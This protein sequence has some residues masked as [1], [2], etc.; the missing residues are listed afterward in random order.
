MILFLLA[1]GNAPKDAAASAAD[2]D[3]YSDVKPIIDA[4]C[5]GCHVTGGIAPFPLTTYAEAQPMAPAMAGAVSARI[6]PPWPADSTCTDYNAS[7]A[8]TDDQI[9]L[10]VGWAD[11]GAAEGDAAKEGL[12]LDRPGG[13]SRVDL[14]LPM[15]N[16]YTPVVS[17]DEYRCFVIDWPEKT[18]TYVTG[19]RAKPGN[20]AIVHHVIA[21]HIPAD[22]ADDFSALDSGA[23]YE[24]L[25][26][27]GGPPGTQAQWIGAWA[28]GDLGNDFP[29][30]T[31]MAIEAGSLVVLQIHYNTST[32]EA[33]P[34]VTAVEVKTDSSVTKQA[35]IVKW[36]DPLWVNAGTMDIPAGDVTTHT[37]VGTVP[38]KQDVTV[39]SSGL[40]MHTLGQEGTL[41]L[42][43]DGK[44]ECLLEIP[45]WDFHWQGTY[46]F[47]E[48]KVAHGG[49]EVT[50]SCTFNN[51]TDTDIAWGEGTEDEMCLGLMYVTL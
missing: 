36:F 51:T 37:W 42:N 10:I 29:D 26:G 27:P 2:I 15:P 30:G 5:T 7:R 19:F 14:D 9:A 41:S 43:T 48:P 45:N 8:L 1:C 35:R 31:G 3:Y 4:K 11:Q 49:D 12:P 34:D 18:D 23:G 16:A 25:G 22:E 24:C 46:W 38:G 44:D 20:A 21:Y 17:P 47:S 39:Y 32:A 50:V 13:M 6:M 33:A 40:H 28:P